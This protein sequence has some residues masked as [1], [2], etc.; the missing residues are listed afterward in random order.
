MSWLDLYFLVRQMITQWW[1]G[2]VLV[3]P[4]VSAFLYHERFHTAN[5]VDHLARTRRVPRCRPG[6]FRVSITE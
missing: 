1:L 5:A 3:L 4:L 2:A 6:F